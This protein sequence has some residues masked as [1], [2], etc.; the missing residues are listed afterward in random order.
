[1]K[2]IGL[3]GGIGS[4]K[5]TVAEYFR[6]LGIPV[7]NSD[8]AAK[9]LM[10]DS[11]QLRKEI[12]KLFG[13]EAYQKGILNREFLAERVFNDAALLEGLNAIVH[14]AV[15]REFQEWVEKQDAPYVIQEAAILFEGGAYKLLDEMILVWA[16]K[17]LRIKRVMK[18][19][20]KTREQVLARMDNQWG[21]TEK[22]ALS[23]HII[24][25][26]HLEETQKQVLAI[27]ASIL[28][29]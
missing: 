25:N 2:V 12:R 28:N 3:T 10:N 9:R 1:M 19:D 8:S 24:E 13:D 23:D 14:P 26:I 21:D 27:H 22:T 20:S 7:F 18:R 6:G 29:K 11:E 16:P 5:S 15:R 17:E 4:G